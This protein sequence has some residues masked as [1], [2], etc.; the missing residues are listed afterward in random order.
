MIRSEFAVQL[1]T[2]EAAL[3]QLECESASHAPHCIH[4]EA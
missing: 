2:V 4:I 3:Q 1:V